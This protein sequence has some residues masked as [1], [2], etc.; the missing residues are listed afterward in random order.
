[1][2]WILRQSSCGRLSKQ[3]AQFVSFPDATYIV[4][5]GRS[6][7]RFQKSL[8]LLWCVLSLY[9][10]LS[11]FSSPRAWSKFFKFH[12]WCSSSLMIINRNVWGSFSKTNGAM[13]AEY[14]L[15]SMS[16]VCKTLYFVIHVQA[17]ESL[18]TSFIEHPLHVQQALRW[19]HWVAV[20]LLCLFFSR[21]V[22]AP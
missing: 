14:M 7:R 17:T 11:S 12:S 21:S 1:M 10:S 9:S 2:S 6:L 13:I 20:F 4:V 16:R 19:A 5:S 8:A 22:A 18:G 3:K 15:L